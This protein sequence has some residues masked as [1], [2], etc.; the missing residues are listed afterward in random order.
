MTGVSDYSVTLTWDPS[1]DNSGKLSYQLVSSAGIS[2]LVPM[3]Y[4]SYTF[5]THHVAGQSYSFYVYATDPSKNRSGNSNTAFATLRAEGSPPS[6]PVLTVTHVGPRHI[7]VSWTTPSDA[8]PPVYF[9]LYA[10]GQPVLTATQATSYTLA[11]LSPG[12]THTLTVK[13]RDGKARYSADSNVVQVTTPAVDPNDTTPPTVPA[14]LWAG[15]FGDAEFQAMWTASTDN[16]MAQVYIH[17][18]VYVNGTWV[19]GTFGSRTWIT[20]YGV[21]GENTLEVIASDENGNS[22]APARLVFTLP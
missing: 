17:Y 15:G 12:S 5:T 8:G 7:S 16:Y 19:G 3:Y 20:D 2:A 18:D 13:A 22:S 10:D 14:D 9:F 21:F 1:T 11:F 4:T 6:P